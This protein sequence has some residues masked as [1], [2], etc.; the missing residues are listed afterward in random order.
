MFRTRG[1][2]F[3]KTAVYTVT[4]W[5]SVLYMH[6]YKQSSRQTT[7]WVSHTLYYLHQKNYNT[8]FFR[9][10]AFCWFILCNCVN[11]A[12]LVH[13][14]MVQ[15]R[16]SIPPNT[17]N[18]VEIGN[19]I[20]SEISYAFFWAVTLTSLTDTWCTPLQKHKHPSRLCRLCWAVTSR[21]TLLC[22]PDS[23]QLFTTRTHV[24]DSGRRR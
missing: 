5:Y 17:V 18:V 2:I 20:D 12:H 4:V 22:F 24:S 7:V 11:K 16:V 6:Q 23:K 13:R 1:F 19:P 14:L 21:Y 10:R 15:S 8:I 3:R 9:K